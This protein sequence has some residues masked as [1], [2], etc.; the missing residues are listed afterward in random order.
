MSRAFASM[1]AILSDKAARLTAQEFIRAVGSTLLADGWTIELFS[2][3]YENGFV[4]VF[5]D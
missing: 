3:V 1:R 2:K 5:E 4:L